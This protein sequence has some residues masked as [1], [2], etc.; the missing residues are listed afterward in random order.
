MDK[1]LRAVH[2]IVCR[3]PNERTGYFGWPTVARM[4]DGALWVVSSGLRT[5]HVCPYGKG[6]L[7]V[8]T[9]GGRTWS[10]PRVIHDTPLD[11]RDAGILSLGGAR[12]LV[13]WFTSDTRN[14][15]EWGRQHVPAD[16][17]AQWRRTTDAWTD[18]TIK[19]W[20]GSWVSLTDDGGATWSDPIRAQ[21]SSPHGPTMLRSGRLLYIGKRALDTQDMYVGPILA[22][23]SD[24]GGRTWDWLGQVPTIPGTF[25]GS[26]YEPHLL[27]LPSGKLL[28]AIR[29]EEWGPKDDGGRTP[30]ER[31]G[32]PPFSIALTDS[33]DGGRTWSVPRARGFHGS[34]PHLMRH[35]S[36]AILLTYGRRQEPLGQRVA[37]SRDDGATW[38]HDLILRDDAPNQDL[39]Y[40]STVELPDGSLF[41]VYYQQAAAGEK[42]SLLWSRWWV[43]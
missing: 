5:Q 13:S 34:P 33:S 4:P 2:G 19:R 24:D 38:E 32:I 8:S 27:E 6:V 39:G 9:D 35:S 37:I 16:E 21:V 31:L 3:I 1:R 25:S 43:E 40:P 42:C 20:L 12:A 14:L 28:A 7:N 30:L 11:D 26:Y 18:D 15:W 17:L 29:L 41:S 22:S 36:G 10:P 23:A